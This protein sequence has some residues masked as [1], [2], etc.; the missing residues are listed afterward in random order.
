MTPPIKSIITP[1]RL[2]NLFSLFVAGTF[3]FVLLNI[4][5]KNINL[6]WWDGLINGLVMIT[7]ITYEIVILSILSHYITK[8]KESLVNDFNKNPKKY[9]YALIV[10][11]AISMVILAYFSAG[12]GLVNAILYLVSLLFMILIVPLNKG[13]TKLYEK[14]IEKKE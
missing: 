5:P 10:I 2:V 3:S 1:E 8:G 9:F 7:F 14:Y 6:N 11:L 13:L 12:N 4:L